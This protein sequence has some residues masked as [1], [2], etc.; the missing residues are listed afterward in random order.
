MESF[1]ALS[2]TK[3]QVE[4]VIINVVNTISR[5]SNT[6]EQLCCFDWLLRIV[7]SVKHGC[8]NGLTLAILAALLFIDWSIRSL[9]VVTE[10][11]VGPRAWEA[12]CWLIRW[13]LMLV[14]TAG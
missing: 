1:M 10:V 11:M 13:S 8:H 12:V 4:I 3:Y 2:M 14:P 5:L 9:L 6:G 7:H